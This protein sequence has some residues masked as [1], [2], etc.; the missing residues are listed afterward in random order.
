MYRKYTPAYPLL[1]SN[2]SHLIFC[3]SE[4][5]EIQ[6]SAPVKLDVIVGAIH[7]SPV[8]L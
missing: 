4:L 3:A 2:K 8:L 6:Q 5:L 1:V 7:E